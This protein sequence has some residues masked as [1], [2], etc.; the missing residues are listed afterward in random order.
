MAEWRKVTTEII[1][2]LDKVYEEKKR[3][4]EEFFEEQIK[5]TV[6]YISSHSGNDGNDGR[7]PLTP[8]KSC[9]MLSPSNINYG[10]IV[11]FEC[12]S[13]FR[14][15]IDIISGVTYSS[16]G[17][18]EKPLFYGSFDASNRE[19][20]E[21][22]DNELY[23][24]RKSIDMY[25]DIGNVVFDGGKAWGIKVQKCDD[26]D[27]SLALKLVTNGI[28]FFEEIPSVS[29]ERAEHMPR[30]DLAFFHGSDNYVYLCSK[31]GAPADR[32]SSIELSRSV[33][34]FNNYGYVE[35]VSF[36]NLRF[37][38]VGCF[39]IRT[40]GCKNITIRNCSFEFIGGAIQ[41]YYN[42]PWRN[43]RTRY[44]NA[45][46]NWGS[47]DGMTIEKCYFNQI[48]DAGITTQ[49][50]DATSCMKNLCFHD[51]VFDCNQ[52]AIELWGGGSESKFENM[53]VVGNVCNRVGDGLTTQRPDKGH[54][55]FF[56]SKGRHQIKNCVVTDN[57]SNG[58]VNCM[59][60]S[61]RLC[62]EE[63][64][65][66]YFFDRNVYVH[67]IGKCFALISKEYPNF[68]GDIAPVEYCE[69]TFELLRN[70]L[71]EENGIFYY[72]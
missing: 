25:Q 4:T 56:N 16:Y 41:F 72:I 8:W 64:K 62:N 29:F 13:V 42:C 71:F 20:W 11:L 39:A 44:G 60:R 15:Q 70:Q 57:I 49:S 5:G 51:N 54:E 26:C 34:I 63:Y 40:G 52:Y 59:L 48:Y 7:T 43:Y 21:Q 33:K 53:S 66:G 23:R 27:M 65:D 14:E 37:A 12:G 30:V 69:K 50:N 58:S 19:M 24:Y 38:C 36:S 35:D 3:K 28:D 31:Y 67:E 47:C 18:G 17:D 6:H 32:F 1:S 2:E 10:D 61:N 68:S 46:E 45:I 55:S 9:A 22:V